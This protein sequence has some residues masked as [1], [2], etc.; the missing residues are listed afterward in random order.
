MVPHERKRLIK[1][2]IDREIYFVPEKITVSDALEFAGFSIYTPCGVGGCFACAV[3]I[4]SETKLACVT[5]AVGGMQ[6][7]TVGQSSP[8]RV[9]SGFA[10]HLVGGVG[11]PY[12]L[13]S[14]THSIEVTCF[15]HGCNYRCPQ[16][17]NHVMAFTGG[18]AMTPET[19]AEMLARIKGVYQVERVAFSGG[20]CTLNRK[21][22][23]ESVKHLK[24]ID[25]GV[26][27][28]VDTN[29]SLLTSDYIDELVDVGM[30]DLGIDL[31]ALSLDTFTRITAV[32]K[33]AE[34]YLKTAWNAVK[35]I[36]DNH[37]I[38]IGIGIPYNKALTSPE[39]IGA[40][41]KEIAQMSAD[42][43]VSLLDYRPAFKR[44]DLTI[45]TAAEMAEMKNILNAAGLD[46][47]IA[48]TGEG[49]IGP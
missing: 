44:R 10:P 24:R 25:N 1:I 40:M 3:M 42:V 19:V 23:I 48:Q 12:A 11:T 31:K 47:V 37:D 26:R 29:G 17:Q 7:D 46:N 34:R 8:L 35:Y 36:L 41:G 49:Y 2:L 9:V 21:F 22:L 5:E 33:D 20:E 15:M 6:I 45:P 14:R 43:Q 30:T 39:E 18:V 27:I 38:F 16:C 4:D 13:K 28:H 32:S